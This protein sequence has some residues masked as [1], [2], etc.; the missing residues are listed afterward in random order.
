MQLVVPC[1]STPLKRVEL[2]D[3]LFK[4]IIKETNKLF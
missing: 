3:Y 1:L 2:I 4:L